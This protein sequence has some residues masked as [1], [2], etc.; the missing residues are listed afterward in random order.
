MSCQLLERRETEVQRTFR[1]WAASREAQRR[2]SR[3]EV[4]RALIRG[5]RQVHGCY[6]MGHLRRR[7]RRRPR[8]NRFR[9]SSVPVFVLL[10]PV[11][12]AVL[13]AGHAEVQRAVLQLAQRVGGWAGQSWQGTQ[14]PLSFRE[15]GKQL[16]RRGG[17]LLALA[18]LGQSLPEQE[19]EA[20]RVEGGGSACLRGR[21]VGFRRLLVLLLQPHAVVVEP[22]GD[23][24]HREA[25]F[26]REELHDRSA[27]VRIQRVGEFQG[28]L[29][30][31]GK[32]DAGFLGGRGVQEEGVQGV[33]LLLLRVAAR[34]V[35]RGTVRIDG[36]AA[37]FVGWNKEIFIYIYLYT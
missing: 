34:V 6:R 5:W 27:R 15:I 10:H 21:R 14:G 3:I 37:S 35:G 17:Q 26:G 4:W 19:S 20:N 33:L 18:H 36:I 9:R 23:G 1:T 24:P 11:I 29:L 31:L 16:V 30:L 8:R 12:F 2:D 32:Q 13:V 25:Q 28:F 7:I 22:V